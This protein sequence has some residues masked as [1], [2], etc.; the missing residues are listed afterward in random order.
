[1]RAGE[2]HVD[3]GHDEQREDRADDHAADEHDADAVARAGAGS[4]REHQRKVADHGR[5]GR[6]QDRPQPRGR[7]LDHRSELVCGRVSCSSFANCTIRIP[8]FDTRP[9][10]VISPTWL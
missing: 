7:R 2:E 1:M 10:S 9:T 8:F 6:H 5:R 4:G 3:R